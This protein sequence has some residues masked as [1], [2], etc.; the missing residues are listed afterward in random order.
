MGGPCRTLSASPSPGPSKRRLTSPRLCSAV[1]WPPAPGLHG[2]RS[3]HVP[4]CEAAVHCVCRRGEYAASLL[5]SFSIPKGGEA[6]GVQAVRPGQRNRWDW[7]ALQL[8]DRGWRAALPAAC[9]P[10]HPRQACN[11]LTFLYSTK[12]ACALPAGVDCGDHPPITP[13]RCATEAELG[14]GDAWR[15]YE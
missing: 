10:C 6:A 5:G 7:P 11:H 13:V 2:R 14:G 9:P 3:Q 1:S 15:L 12:P 4:A 8:T